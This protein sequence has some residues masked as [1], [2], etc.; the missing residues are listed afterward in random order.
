VIT[1]LI[2][3]VDAFNP[4]AFFVL[5]FLLSLM[6]HTGQR[7][8]MLLVGGVFVFFSGLLYFLFMTAWLNL[9]RVIGHLEAIT[10]GAAVVALLIGSINIKDFFWFKRGVSLSISESA[11]P[12]LFQRMR[13]LLQ[14]R[15]LLTLILAASGLA[16]FANLYE[17]L[18]TAGFPLVYT[19]I[20]TLSELSSLQYY[21]YL[22]LYN[23]VYVMPL[24][25]IVLLFVMAMGTRK[26]QEGEGRL[27]KLLSGSM[28]LM[29]GLV[30]LF[31]PDV[32]Q[33]LLMTLL[34]L[35]ASIMVALILGYIHKRIRQR[36][37]SAAISKP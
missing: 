17:F 30:L 36:H 4:C 6:L 26:L 23:T 16:L 2:A 21:S 25:V 3:A 15:S 28:M 1:V 14:T 29:L 5:M 8:R 24:L 20:L 31:A 19:R 34:L 37:T 10:I 13:S 35:I 12:K 32:L 18:C 11:K 7:R 9:F 27:L 33:D 22:L